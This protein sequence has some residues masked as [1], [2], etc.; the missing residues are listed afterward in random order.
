MAL[1]ALWLHTGIEQQRS[2]ELGGKGKNCLANICVS[3][4]ALWNFNLKVGVSGNFG[5]CVF[6]SVKAPTCCLQNAFPTQLAENRLLNSNILCVIVLIMFIAGRMSGL[7]KAEV[8]A[9]DRFG[10][11]C[12]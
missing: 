1:Q 2:S 9:R 6:N 4:L 8:I 11:K 5:L 10:F 7:A 12:I 3:Q